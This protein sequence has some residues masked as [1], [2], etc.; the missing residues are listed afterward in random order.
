MKARGRD[1]EH[2]A[3]S[4]VCASGWGQGTERGVVMTEI[5]KPEGV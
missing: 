2:P 5:A 4:R 3:S 1:Q